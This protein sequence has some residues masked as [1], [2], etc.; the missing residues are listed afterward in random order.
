M[1]IYIAG[2]ISNNPNYKEQF[3]KAEAHIKSLGHTPISPVTD[4]QHTYKGYIDRGLAL[5]SECDAIY[6]LDGWFESKGARVEYMYSHTV[7]IKVYSKGAIEI[8]ECE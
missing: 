8:G 7:G 6:M 3:A 5:L 1:K 2:S 4:E